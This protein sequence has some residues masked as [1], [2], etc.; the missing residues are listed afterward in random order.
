MLPR[1][2]LNVRMR[3]NEPVCNVLVVIVTVA[4]MMKLSTCRRSAKCAAVFIKEASSTGGALNN[5]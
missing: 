3:G 5:K 4:E 1:R 2:S